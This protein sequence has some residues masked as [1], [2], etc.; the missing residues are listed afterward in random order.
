MKRHAA[1][2]PLSRQHHDALA[3]GVFIRRGLCAGAGPRAAERLRR[4]ALDVWSLELSGHFEV[5]ETVLFPAARQAVPEPETV[6]RLLR[7][8]DGI[9]EAFSALEHAG[10][11]ELESSLRVLRERLV[12]HIRFEER[13]VFEA[14]QESMAERDLAAL[15]LEIDA[16]LPRLCVRLGS[17]A[18][19]PRAGS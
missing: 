19:A 15:G 13:V 11:G 4:Q 5:E 14:L 6:D 18:T 10:P 1:L 12:D 17:A 7:E 16:A 3:L 2:V 9:R 8:H